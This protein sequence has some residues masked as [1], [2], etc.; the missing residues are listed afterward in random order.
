MFD[1]DICSATDMERLEKICKNNKLV[2]CDKCYHSDPNAGYDVPY[3]MKLTKL[4]KGSGTS[5]SSSTEGRAP[6]KLKEGN[7]PKK[8]KYWL[9]TKKMYEKRDSVNKIREAQHMMDK[10][11][12]SEKSKIKM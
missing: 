5:C 6:Y 2:R 12:L 8:C 9:S 10:L 4:G 3:C 1:D 11:S 7:I